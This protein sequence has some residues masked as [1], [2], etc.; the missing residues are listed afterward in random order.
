MENESLL[1]MKEKKATFRSRLLIMVS[2]WIIM[3]W[4]TFFFLLH[5]SIGGF[6]ER[7]KNIHAFVGEK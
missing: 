5:G 1:I 7:K 4:W 3:Y 6:V 2:S